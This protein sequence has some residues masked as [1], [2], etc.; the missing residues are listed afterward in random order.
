M[1][2]INVYT[3]DQQH[4][5]W[6]DIDAATEIARYREHSG[7]YGGGKILLAT[8]NGKLVV[9]A[10]DNLGHNNYRFIKAENEIAKILV[11]GGYDGDDKK[12]TEI[13]D[14]YEI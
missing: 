6:F 14:K 13:L 3:E 4:R 5:G 8:A 9:N 7:A 12:L 11:A 10:W 2:R 1:N